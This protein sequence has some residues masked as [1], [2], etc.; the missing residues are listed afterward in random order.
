MIAAPHSLAAGI[1]AIEACQ[2]HVWR[3]EA[4]VPRFSL[5]DEMYVER[6]TKADWECLKELHYKASAL[7]IGPRFWKLTLRGQTIGV[8]VTCNPKGIL[9]ERQV[10]FPAIKITGEDT[11]LSN[12]MRFKFANDNFRCVS[13]FVI[14][15]MY[16]GVGAG[17][18][19]MNLVSRMEGNRYMEIQSSMSKFNTFGVSAGFKFI[20]PM[21]STKF[22]TGLKFF[23][24]TFN[25]NPQD[26]EAI[27]SEIEAKSLPEQ[28]AILEA[29][30]DFYHKNSV[31]E[32]T[33]KNRA[34][35][36]E[37]VERLNAR[38]A[39]KQLQQLA[40]A[41]PLYGLW[42]NPDWRLPVPER[43]PLSAFDTQGP[44]ERLRWQPSS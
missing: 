5:L 40:L 43:L 41:S 4:P 11:R 44:R 6:G 9:K 16:R 8:L 7:S 10:I 2:T 23:R 13:R 36:L 15:T 18:R 30:K 19:M 37:R 31:L 22:A 32:K 34:H 17:Y 35:G 27:V 28:A 1:Q 38:T 26:F 25:A 3:D 20:K 39:V 14:D 33:G 21:N 12:T 24:S 42:Q 29:C